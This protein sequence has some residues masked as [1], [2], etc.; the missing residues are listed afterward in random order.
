MVRDGRLADIAAGR[1]VAGADLGVAG[2]LAD[3]RQAGRVA[4]RLEE[5]DV[6]VDA[7]RASVAPWRIISMTSILTSID[8]DGILTSVDTTALRQEPR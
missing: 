7:G 4:E 6:G 5:A 2:Q 8:T 3:D 1:E